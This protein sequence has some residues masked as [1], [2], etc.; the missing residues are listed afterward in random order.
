MNHDGDIISRARRLGRDVRRMLF[1][2]VR[3]FALPLMIAV[4][5][6]Y[7][8][9]H[10]PLR[11]VI[12]A[13]LGAK[14]RACYFICLDALMF[15]GAADSLSAWMLIIVAALAAWVVSDWFD[16][17]SYERP[18]VFGLSALAFV[19]V[20][21]AIIG[22]L[23]SWSGTA[24]LRPPLGPL[25]SA[26]PALIVIG[27]GLRSGWRPHLPERAQ[28]QPQSL[29]LLVGGLA[30]A[31]LLVSAS[32]SFMHPPSGYDALGW[33]APLAFFLWRDG[34]LSTFLDRAPIYWPL[35][36]PGTVELLFGLLRFAGGEGLADLGQLP[37]AVLGGFAV[38][39]F[40]RRLGLGRGAA[41]LAAG[42]YL[43][44][45][46]VTIHA[47]I[48]VADVAGAGLLMATV[49]LASASVA[50][51][52]MGRLVVI[53]FSLGLVI[54]TKLALLPC[55][56]AMMF[57]VVLATFWCHRNKMQT[58]G[59]RFAL[60]A[61]MF[62]LVVAPWWIRNLSRYDNPV[63]PAGIPWIA[64]GI[65]LSDIPKIDREFVPSPLAW[66]L[67]SLFERYSERSG[68][69]TLFALGVIPGLIV[70]VR[71]SRRQPLTLY[72]LIAAFMLPAWWILTHHDARYLLALFSLGFAFL[73]FSLLAV[74]RRL[75]YV[76][77]GLV[78][79]AA[80][81]SVLLTCDQILLPSARQPTARLEFYDV[82]WGVDPLV[83]S[84][85]ETNGLLLHMGHANYTYPSYYPL[86]GPTLSR[87]VIPV[88][89]EATTESI[90]ADMRSAGLHYAYVT[91][92]PKSHSTVEELY[93]QSQ[94]ELVHVSTVNEG[95]RRGT[96]RYL[97]R[98]RID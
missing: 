61:F 18:L 43:L 69:G 62:S 83:A 22:G 37:F 48:Q 27:V 81:F 66:P 68:V 31:L 53:A 46:V 70:A 64:R 94:F 29:V 97:Y 88:D 87:L 33:H 95:W 96:R 36:C 21:S 82:V 23:G 80:I 16:G 3:R 12:A 19:S 85:P 52:T 42:A 54:T 71:R 1:D 67:F 15:R 5:G 98:L 78:A 49:A 20:P 75:R 11:D 28:R 35:A 7:I 60:A 57:F 24:L 77:C 26:I 10:S 32:I 92:L 56:V 59:V 34:N 8:A 40:T 74:P 58:L 76:G 89:T 2:S 44:A 91:A 65:T 39:A 51:W 38:G 72:S 6:L 41:Q 86:L 47:G 63:Y 93:D 4:S 73:P 30:A 13:T 55:V 9:A 17:A 45:P 79:A 50:N 84:L 25:L 90:V 14:S